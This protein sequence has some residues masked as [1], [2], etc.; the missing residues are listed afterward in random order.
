MRFL[1]FGKHHKK[2]VKKYADKL[3]L[4]QHFMRQKGKKKVHSRKEVCAKPV[5]DISVENGMYV[6]DTNASVVV[7]SGILLHE[8]ERKGKSC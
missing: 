6:L 7:V 4:M 8:Q 3:Y 5:L 2:F 1:G